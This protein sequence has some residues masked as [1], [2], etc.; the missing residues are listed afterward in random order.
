MVDQLRAAPTRAEAS[1]PCRAFAASAP[2]RDDGSGHPA[3]PLE[4]L[5]QLRL[6]WCGADPR[7]GLLQRGEKVPHRHRRH[8][9]L[10]EPSADEL[11][12]LRGGILGDAAREGDGGAAAGTSWRGVFGFGGAKLSTDDDAPVYSRSDVRRMRAEWS[13]GIRS[14][15]IDSVGEEVAPLGSARAMVQVAEPDV[16]PQG[17]CKH[18]GLLMLVLACCVLPIMQVVLSS[19]GGPMGAAVATCCVGA[20]LLLCCGY[21]YQRGMVQKLLAGDEL[22]GWCL[23]VSIYALLVLASVSINL[24]CLVTAVG[25]VAAAGGNGTVEKIRRLNQELSDE[26]PPETKAYYDSREFKDK[27]DKLFSAADVNQNGR[28]ELSELRGPLLSQITGSHDDIL[29]D[30]CFVEAFDENGNAEIEQ[31]EFHEMMRYFDM[32]YRRRK[33][34]TP[35]AAPEEAPLEKALHSAED[36]DQT[37]LAPGREPQPPPG[38]EAPREAAAPAPVPLEETPLEAAG[39]APVSFEVAPPL[40]PPAATLVEPAPPAAA[41]PATDL[42]VPPTAQMDTQIADLAAQMDSLTSRLAE[43][44][45]QET[46]REDSMPIDR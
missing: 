28:L 30:K 46:P 39:S 1:A 17:D 4:P 18:L 35:A 20:A 44:V 36:L 42:H 31:A 5:P 40:P 38:M 14:Q 12:E 21:L 13:Q 7:A 11:L 26:L 29:Q 22:E 32:V 24:C 45:S 33:E 19:R 2:T 43:L 27:C 16:M 10:E 34:E 23:A 41:P 8:Y 3:A 15:G 6:R 9:S 25:A 37:K